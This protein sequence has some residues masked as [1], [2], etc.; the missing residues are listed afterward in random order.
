MECSLMISTLKSVKQVQI[1][2]GALIYLFICGFIT[3]TSTFYE[4][5]L[6]S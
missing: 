5:P 3:L 4:T 1:G 6:E 2:L